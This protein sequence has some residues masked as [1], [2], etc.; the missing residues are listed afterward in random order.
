MIPYN[1]YDLTDTLSELNLTYKSVRNEYQLEGCPFCESG[2][3]KKSDH[4]SFSKD[5]GQFKCLKCEEIGNL[6]TFRRHMGLDPFK[7]ETFKLPDQSRVSKLREQPKQYYEQYSATRSVSM[8]TLEKYGVGKYRDEKL[9]MCRT[10]QY[11]DLEGKI[12]NIKYINKNKQMKTEYQARKIYYGLQFVDFGKDFLHIVCG[13]D[14]VHALIDIGIDNVVSLPFGDKNYTENM[15]EINK[16]FKVLYLLLDNDESGQDGAKMFSHKAG[17]WKCINIFLPFNDARECLQ[18]GIDIFAIEKLKLEGKRFEYTPED[19]CRPGLSFEERHQRYIA[20]LVVGDGLKFGFQLIDDVIGGIRPGEVISVVANPGAYKTTLAMNLII[21]MASTLSHGFIMFF[22]LEMAI[23]SE[24][25][26]ELGIVTGLTRTDIKNFIDSPHAINPIIEEAKKGLSRI[27]VSEESYINLDQM[28]KVIKK[29]EDVFGEPCVLV[30]CDY[31]DF[32]EGRK[33]G[34]E[35]ETIK[36]V[37]NGFKSRLC[38]SEGLS[39]IMLYQTN[40]GTKSSEEEVTA[41]SGKGGTPIE[42]GSDFQLGLWRNNG[43]VGRFTKHRRISDS[44][45]GPERPYF[46]CVVPNPKTFKITDIHV[47]DKNELEVGN[48]KS[49]EF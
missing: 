17:V 18:F 13:E 6:I 32:V 15:G 45:D 25:E 47:I 48:G 39:G 31:S 10:Y 46:R 1:Q 8:E 9:G 34:S 41:R 43:V 20:S 21:K 4:F 3:G 11:V 49:V 38:R 7:K 30:A 42:A 23:E 29:T 35:Y 24:F 36:E 16:R 28:K 5:T 37:A 26:R 27:M 44:W 33:S 19:T 12:A 14:D 2:R 22:S 40:R